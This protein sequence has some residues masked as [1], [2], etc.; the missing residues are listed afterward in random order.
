MQLVVLVSGCVYM[1]GVGCWCW[2]MGER[3]EDY[4]M[5]GVRGEMGRLDGP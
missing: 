3:G 4:G 1:V 2:V 5:D